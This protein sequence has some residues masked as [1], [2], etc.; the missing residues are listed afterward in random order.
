ME[1]EPINFT[2][3]SDPKRPELKAIFSVGVYDTGQA[4]PTLWIN[5]GRIYRYAGRESELFVSMPYVKT[6]IQRMEILRFDSHQIR[7][8]FIEKTKSNYEFKI[9]EHL[10]MEKNSE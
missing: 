1:I 9:L 6:E 3:V 5:G 7:T 10:G 2:I 8:D 4:K